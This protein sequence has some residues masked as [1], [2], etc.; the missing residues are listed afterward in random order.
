MAGPGIAI[1]VPQGWEA[2]IYQPL[3]EHPTPGGTPVPPAELEN[4]PAV[5]HAANFPLPPNRSDF[6]H[7]V[8]ERLSL[9]HVF[10]ALV[11]YGPADAAKALFAAE[12]FPEIHPDDLSPGAVMGAAT[13][14]AAVQRFFHVGDR[15]FSVYAAVGSH[16]MRAR[17]APAI[18][19]VLR[20]IE[21]F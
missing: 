19:E 4:A 15:A 7:D 16:R 21:L 2:E 3:R 5:L 11:E 12:G 1:E 10:I 20:G 17:L 8:I 6:G 13:G 14:Q 9:M 18:A